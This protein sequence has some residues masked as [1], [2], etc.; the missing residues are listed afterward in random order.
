[1]FTPPGGSL[2]RAKLNGVV[3]V[4]LCICDLYAY[5]RG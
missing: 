3:F 1:M 5:V 4:V 2:V